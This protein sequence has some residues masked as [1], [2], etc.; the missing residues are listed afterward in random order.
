[1]QKITSLAKK[2]ANDLTKK[3]GLAHLTLQQGEMFGWD[4]TACTIT[5]R[6][7][8]PHA[9][10]YLL[11]ECGHALLGHAEYKRDIE[12]LP[13]ERAAWDEALVLAA[14]YTLAI[15]T[16]LIE[17][18]LDTY[19]DWLHARSLCPTCEATGIQTAPQTYTCLACHHKWRVNEARSCALR[20]YSKQT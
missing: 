11:H 9:I 20:R 5:Y 19:R 10:A 8:E 4:H 18:A 2:L 6:V 3:P 13:M 17:D 1:M 16:D 12:L 15:D 7:D 14:Q